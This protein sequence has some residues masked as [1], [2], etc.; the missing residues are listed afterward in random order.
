[1]HRPQGQDLT[2]QQHVFIVNYRCSD[3]SETAPTVEVQLQQ[4]LKW[5]AE[6]DAASG[7]STASPPAPSASSPSYC[8]G[9]NRDTPDAAAPADAGPA[10]I[11]FRGCRL[12]TQARMGAQR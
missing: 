12:H 6:A 5:A 2:S 10:G 4:F 7:P 9:A 11:R 1:M 8:D 3:C